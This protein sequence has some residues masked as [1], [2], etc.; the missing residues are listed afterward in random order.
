VKKVCA[1]AMRSVISDSGAA[2]SSGAGGLVTGVAPVGSFTRLSSES[3]IEEA[4]AFRASSVSG[5][6]AAGEAS[7]NGATDPEAAVD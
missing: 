3:A 4:S 5:L 1:I 7:T 6:G 2:V